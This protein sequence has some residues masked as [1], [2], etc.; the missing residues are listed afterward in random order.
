[1]KERLNETFTFVLN[2]CKY[3]NVGLVFLHSRKHSCTNVIVDIHVVLVLRYEY[4]YYRDQSTSRM[5]Y[6]VYIT[7]SN[8]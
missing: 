3:L 4:C 8:Y 5:T 7:D 2:I 6:S 1:M